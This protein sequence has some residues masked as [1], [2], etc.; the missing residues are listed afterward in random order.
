MWLKRDFCTKKKWLREISD[1]LLKTVEYS[2]VTAEFCGEDWEK[3]VNWL[4]SDSGY[5][6]HWAAILNVY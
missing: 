4:E 6:R 5:W 3:V 1:W 2:V